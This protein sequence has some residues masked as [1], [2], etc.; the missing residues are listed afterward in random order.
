MAIR[1]VTEILVNRG[2]GQVKER[3]LAEIVN[4][5]KKAFEDAMC[6]R[7]HANALFQLCWEESGDVW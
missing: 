4:P 7:H 6:E 2:R 5:M 3:D 1:A